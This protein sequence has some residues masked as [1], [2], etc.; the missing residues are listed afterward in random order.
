MVFLGEKFRG[1]C[2]WTALIAGTVIWQPFA[3]A[4][5]TKAISPQSPN[6]VVVTTP[7][8]NKIW[9]EVADTPE[10]RARGLMFRQRLAKDH[11]M[12]FTFPEP[13]HWTIWMKNMK[14][15]LDII[16]LDRK[17]TIV[18]V[19]RHVPG[20]QLPGTECPQYQP[21]K[22]SS[23]VLE[24]SAGAAEFLKLEKGVSLKFPDLHSDHGPTP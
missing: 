11:G 8:G 14:I 17:K 4:T 5:A 12:L 18:H 16:W 19:E 2:L 13:Q 7:L 21:S 20:C 6:I 3:H 23:F 22:K 10:R 1:I 9:A 15:P 24:L